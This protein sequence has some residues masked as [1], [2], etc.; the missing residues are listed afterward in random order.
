MSPGINVHVDRWPQ[1]R[2]RHGG[3][4]KARRIVARTGTRRRLKWR[5]GALPAAVETAVRW[6]AAV[7]E[8]DERRDEAVVGERRGELVVDLHERRFEIGAAGG[9]A[10]RSIAC[11]CVTDSA[12]AMP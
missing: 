7:E 2:Q 6:V 12:G 4:R 10:M 9:N 5:I 11:I 8:P 1:R 3:Q